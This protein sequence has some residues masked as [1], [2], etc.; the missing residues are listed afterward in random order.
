MNNFTFLKKY[1]RENLYYNF[2]DD[3]YMQLESHP[4]F[5]SLY[6]IVD[7]FDFFEIEN[8]ALKIEKEEL[9]NLPHSFLSVV[10]SETGKEIVFT[11]KSKNII[12]IEF[13]NGFKKNISKDEYLKIWT[14]IIVAI[15]SNPIKESLLL[16]TNKKD[17]LIFG[18]VFVLSTIL[19]FLINKDNLITGIFYFFL[20]LTGLI[21]SYFLV[22]E[23]MGFHNDSISKICNVTEKT[24]CKDVL[25]SNGAKV[26]KNLSL[27]DISM[28]YFSSLTFFSILNPFYLNSSI[29]SIIGVFSLPVILYSVYYQGII[30]KKWCLLCLGIDTVL[31]LQLIVVS[32]NFSLVFNI[33]TSISFFSGL[34]I[35]ALFYYLGYQ[36]KNKILKI[37]KNEDIVLEFHKLKRNNIVFSSLLKNSQKIDAV[38]LNSLKTITIGKTDSPITLFLALSASCGHCHTAYEKVMKL[39]KK[40]PNE[41]KIKLL[42]NVNIEN[43]E[44]PSNI[45][46]KQASH[47]YWS[48]EVDKAIDS[49]NDWHIERMDLEKWKCKWESI[50]LE[51][52]SKIIPNQYNWCLENNIHYTP[53]IILNGHIMPN[54]YQINDLN[55]FIDELIEEK[56][57]YIEN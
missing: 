3:F 56:L 23:E 54:E 10:K 5:P 33:A 4:N 31:L 43:T 30:V 18:G 2:E 28:L 40:N 49:L 35:V 19:L 26:L 6:A 13:S 15:E 47:Y 17:T 16:Y 39:A 50:Y 37:T 24:S 45:V 25:S 38:H 21:I 55:Y 41:V 29:Y 11:E 44:N 7:T 51:S 42:F 46:Y 48:G 22:R 1:L 53:A 8:V 12:T 9:E 20:S 14:G 32:F 34:L 27:S 36:L 52:S 57:S